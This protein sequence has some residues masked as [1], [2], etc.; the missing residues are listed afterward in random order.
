[1]EFREKGISFKF[2]DAKLSDALLRKNL[3]GLLNEAAKRGLELPAYSAAVAIQAAQTTPEHPEKFESSAVGSTKEILLSH[4][5][6]TVDG[7]EAVLNNL[8]TGRNRQEQLVSGGRKTLEREFNE[9]FS[10]PKQQYVE[11]AMLADPKLEF[12]L[13]ATP[14]LLVNAQELMSAARAFGVGQPYPTYV[15]EALL[16]QYQAEQLSGTNPDSTH[17]ACFS[18][19]PDSLAYDKNGTVDVQ[20]SKLENTK[21]AYPFLKVPSLFEAVAYWETL[22]AK[23]FKLNNETSYDRTYI[24]HFD[25]PIVQID[26]FNRMP[27]SFVGTDG[28]G[29]ISPSGTQCAFAR[30]AVG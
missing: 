4:F 27:Q 23:G 5:K 26:G 20:R 11:A 13:V 2:E 14:N 12:S 7:Y 15:E 16:Y 21:Q 8:N 18:L 17:T 25:L 3:N 10:T 28:G 22:R 6:A 1:M 30:I 9:W 29:S 19:I 24:S